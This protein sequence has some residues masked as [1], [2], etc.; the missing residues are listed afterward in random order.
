MSGAFI[1]RQL[2]G[3]AA[4]YWRTTEE[5]ILKL[6]EGM[7]ERDRRIEQKRRSIS[8]E[9][10]CKFRFFLGSLIL[11][12]LSACAGFSREYLDKYTGRETQ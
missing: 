6:R 4:K 8:S 10:S 7:T 11:G 12:S 9:E 5:Y 1:R 3:A 2:D